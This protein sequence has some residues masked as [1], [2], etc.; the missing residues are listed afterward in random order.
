MESNSS[1]KQ[2]Y[3]NT[4]GRPPRK[5]LVEAVVLVENKG[6]ALDLGAGAMQDSIYLL[7]QGFKEVV[8][9]DLESSVK[10]MAP[11]DQRLQVIISSFEDF[12]FPDN[13]FD[14]VNAQFSLPFTHPQHFARVFN[15][16]KKSLKKNG[17]FVG[18]LFGDRD[19]WNKNQDMTFL[20]K[21]NVLSLLDDMEV[22]KMQEEERDGKTAAGNEKHWHLFNLILR[23]K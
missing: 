22:I 14:L 6:F 1:W 13:K 12:N 20:S 18:Q 21:D 23:K 16:V 8:A 10:G 7:E 2:Y 5:E 3:K 4:A 19:E 15:S 9:V 17:V 11:T